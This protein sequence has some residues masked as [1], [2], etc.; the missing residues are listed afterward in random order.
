MRRDRLGAADPSGALVGKAAAQGRCQRD[1]SGRAL[2]GAL[3]VRSPLDL[4]PGAWARIAIVDNEEL[5][6]I[7]EFARRARLTPK[8]LR[9]YDQLGLLSPTVTDPATGYRRYRR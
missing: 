6:S 3:R 1:R 9:I 4:V 8:A 5:L 2:P 7:G